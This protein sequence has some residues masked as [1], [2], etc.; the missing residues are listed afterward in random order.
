MLK[1]QLPCR[2]RWEHQPQDQ[3]TAHNRGDNLRFT[4]I[5]IYRSE[6]IWLHLHF[7]RCFELDFLGLHF[8]RSRN[9]GT[10][11][12][13]DSK[14]KVFHEALGM[15]KR[16]L[17]GT[18]WNAPEVFPWPSWCTTCDLF[19]ISSD[20]PCGHRAGPQKLQ[21]LYVFFCM[22]IPGSYLSSPA[23]VDSKE[24]MHEKK[25]PSLTNTECGAVTAIA[26]RDQSTL[27]S[28]KSCWTLLDFA[29]LFASTRPGTRTLGEHCRFFFLR[30]A[31]L[32]QT[33][34]LGQTTRCKRW[35]FINNSE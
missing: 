16:K 4:Y 11:E 2:R 5:Y 27:E 3:T 1:L 30:P 25:G 15:R 10:P 9:P 24:F 19:E 13:A 31:W 32:G 26:K 12:T 28:V 14:A 18:V 35:L 6:I 29:G 17:T 7:L 8:A 22:A 21:E 20:S 33:R 34:V 23:L